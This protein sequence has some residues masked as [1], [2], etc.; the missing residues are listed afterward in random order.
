[1]KTQCKTDK[2][3]L[4][5]TY[6]STNIISGVCTKSVICGWK[7]QETQSYRWACLGMQHLTKR[8]GYKLVVQQ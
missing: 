7:T 3:N 1:M 5:C 6:E 8:G 2:I 4:P